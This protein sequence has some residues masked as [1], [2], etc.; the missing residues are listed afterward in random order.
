MSIDAPYHLHAALF[1][2]DAFALVPDL[3][4]T[5]RG[6]PGPLPGVPDV[7]APDAPRP[8]AADWT[9]WWRSVLDVRHGIVDA[10]EFESLAGMPDL[11]AAARVAFPAFHAWWNVGGAKGGL[12]RALDTRGIAVT[13]AVARL[14]AELGR[15]AA[16]FDLAIQVLAV[17]EPD[18]LVHDG[19]DAVISVAF[20]AAP[21]RFDAWLD[22]V[23]R[24]LV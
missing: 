14:E 9:A 13:H 16:P 7:R 3:G 15:P 22:G 6:A 21:L 19:D 17:S 11:Q 12:V 5:G 20:L 1:V 2:R 18:V 24:A 23:L 8:S 10:P 4:P